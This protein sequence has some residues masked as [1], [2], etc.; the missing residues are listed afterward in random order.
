[1]ALHR[2]LASS[3]DDEEL[4]ENIRDDE[5]TVLSSIGTVLVDLGEWDKALD[6]YRQSVIVFQQDGDIWDKGAVVQ[7]LITRLEQERHDADYP[8]RRAWYPWRRRR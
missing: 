3:E 4:L 7:E 6:S 2:E 5:A 8:R 1:M